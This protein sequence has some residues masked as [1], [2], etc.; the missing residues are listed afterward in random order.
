MTQDLLLALAAGLLA[1][2]NPCGFALLPAYLSLLV[3]DDDQ[4]GRGRAVVAALVSSAAMTVGFVG[5]FAVFGLV[6][7]PVVSGVQRYLPAVTVVLGVS[8]ALAGIWLV[9]GRSL[10]AF[11]W[12]PRGPRP[13][14]RFGALV[15]FGAAYATASLTCTVAP[16]LAIVVTS[17][18]SGSRWQGLALF[19]AYGLGMGLLVVAAALA[20]AFARTTLLD[21]LRAAGGR[22]ARWTGVL[23]VGVGAYVGYYGWWELQV[24]RGA[25]GADPVITAAANVQ[26][27]LSGA[28][29]RL[30]PAGVATVAAVLA[31]LLLTGGLLRRSRIRVPR[32]RR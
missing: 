5:V 13:S 20:V 26:A 17:F 7:S 28:V 23:L 10:P 30:G 29:G 8:L 24:L 2:V 27:S 16:F 32:G 1:A 14:R 6:L 3:L 11:G 4:P 25:A 9:A 31:G 19:V 21:R 22:A 15:G 12:S 18:R